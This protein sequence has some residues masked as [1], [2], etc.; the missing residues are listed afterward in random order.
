MPTVA[1]VDGIKIQFYWD[2]HPPPHFHVEYA[3]DIA[4]IDIETLEILEGHLPRPQY[5][6]LVTWARA[7]KPELLDA[8][9]ECQSDANPGKIE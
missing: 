1:I 5:R 6:K 9:S 8:W 3:D 4:V 7:R 2:E